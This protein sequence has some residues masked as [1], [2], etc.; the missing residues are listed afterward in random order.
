VSRPQ[1]SEHEDRAVATFAILVI[2]TDRRDS[3]AA[4][5]ARRE[6]AHLGWD[7]RPTNPRATRE[8]V[9]RA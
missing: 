4:N 1:I 3:R 8:G 2:A 9:G 7:V 5:D 6:L